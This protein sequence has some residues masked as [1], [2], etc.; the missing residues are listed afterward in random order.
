VGLLLLCYLVCSVDRSLV[1]PL[2][3]SL[4][5]AMPI[6]RLVHG[7]A[8][9]AGPPFQ[10]EA[11]AHCFVWSHWIIRGVA[12]QRWIGPDRSLW[13]GLLSFPTFLLPSP[14]WHLVVNG[15]VLDCN[16]VLPS[17]SS[18]GIPSHVPKPWPRLNILGFD[19]AVLIRSVR[20]RR[21]VWDEMLQLQFHLL[22]GT[23]Q[24]PVIFTG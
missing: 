5:Q 20:T 11:L 13:K 12:T 16:I 4:K 22:A 7:T 10:Q 21:L 17:R 24:F 2:L 15:L 18:A 14:W 9:G 6:D 8:D 3:V 19:A 1:Y 23:G